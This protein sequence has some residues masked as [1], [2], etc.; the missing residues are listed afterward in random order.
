MLDILYARDP[1]QLG[2]GNLRRIIEKSGQMAHRDIAVFVKGRRKHRAPVLLE[3]L[4]HVCSPAEKGHAKRR[5]GNDHRLAPFALLIVAMRCRTSVLQ[6][7]LRSRPFQ[8]VQ[9]HL[10]AL[11]LQPS[12][13]KFLA[14]RRCLFCSL[15][16]TIFCRLFQVKFDDRPQNIQTGRRSLCAPDIMLFDHASHVAL[17]VSAK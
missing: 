13:Q 11:L 3:I 15:Y 2:V 1:L 12:G 5:F 17:P 4:L 10:F 9:T 16:S 14:A 8:Y 7:H 6:S